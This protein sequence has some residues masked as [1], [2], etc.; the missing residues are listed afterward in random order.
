[1]SRDL[2]GRLV[3]KVSRRSNRSGNKGAALTTF[4]SLAGRYMVL[5]PNNPRAGGISRRIDGDDRSELR[6]AMSSLEIPNGMGVI[7]RTA[8]V[9]RSAEELQWDLEQAEAAAKNASVTAARNRELTKQQLVSRMQLDDSE[10]LE[11][12]T[13]YAGRIHLLVT[14]V[15]MPR[16]GGPQLAERLA[17][18]FPDMCVLFM[19]GYPDT[20]ETPAGRIPDGAEIIE[21]LI[22][23]DYVQRQKKRLIPTPKGVALIDQDGFNRREQF[24]H[25]LEHCRC[26]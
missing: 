8:G 7:I 20:R 26:Q 9:G 19:S 5:M 12:S 11:R 6:E 4:V 24:A 16:M 13:A 18:R 15:V 25:L 22:R 1:M 21:K 2:S 17:V 3:N 10:A 23:T 14:D